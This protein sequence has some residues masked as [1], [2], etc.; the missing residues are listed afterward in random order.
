MQKIARAA[1]AIRLACVS[2]AP[3]GARRPRPYGSSR[4]VLLRHAA[5]SPRARLVEQG[6]NADELPGCGADADP[7]MHA[8]EFR[9]R[10]PE[11]LLMRSAR[12][13][14]FDVASPTM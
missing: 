7:S 11:R 2:N 4:M 6:R 10:G 14:D 5:L 12:H 9:A 1:L 13:D 8:R 3:R